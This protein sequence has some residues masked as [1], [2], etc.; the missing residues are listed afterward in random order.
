M[1][2]LFTMNQMAWSNHI[3]SPLHPLEIRFASATEI[4]S[5]T[6]Q[7]AEEYF[8]FSQSWSWAPV[9]WGF[10][11]QVTNTSGDQREPVEHRDRLAFA[12]D[13][14][15]MY[16]IGLES[17]NLCGLHLRPCAPH[18]DRNRG[19]QINIRQTPTSMGLWSDLGFN[20]SGR[21]ERCNRVFPEAIRS[22]RSFSAWDVWIV[23]T[24]SSRA[25][26]CV[27]AISRPLRNGWL[28]VVDCP[29]KEV[30][31]EETSCGL[32]AFN[33]ASTAIESLSA[34]S[35]SSFSQSSISASWAW[36]TWSWAKAFL[37][38]FTNGQV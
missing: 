31:L 23:S 33:A 18:R 20:G 2:R 29:E 19:K 1:W 10:A 17:I 22:A 24:K 34:W 27:G 32:A 30:G 5:L 36:A 26:F 15:A 25:A 37:R 21:G 3:T 16:R 35:S 12:K 7:M 38:R 8:W 6:F 11:L 28:A 4:G 13:A 14:S 9:L